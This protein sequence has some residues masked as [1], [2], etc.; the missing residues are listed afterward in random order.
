MGLCWGYIGENMNNV[1]E[2]KGLLVAIVM[3]IQHS[4]FA[5]ILEGYSYL[6]LQMAAKLLHGKP[7][8]M[9]VDNWKMVHTLE[10]VRGLLRMHSEVQIHHVKR[11]ENKLLDVLENYGVRQKREFQQ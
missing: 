3:V 9:V 11:K 2:L 6:I 5:I 10:Q 1:D 4:W 7:V 8:N